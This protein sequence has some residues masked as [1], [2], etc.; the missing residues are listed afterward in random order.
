MLVREND[1][2]KEIFKDLKDFRKV[3]IDLF[4]KKYIYKKFTKSNLV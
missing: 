4:I 3:V 1:R 2:S